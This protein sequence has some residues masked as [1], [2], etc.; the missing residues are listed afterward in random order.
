MYIKDSFKLLQE[1]QK[2]LK[3]LGACNKKVREK[4]HSIGYL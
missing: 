2:R 1:Y 3:E 4:T